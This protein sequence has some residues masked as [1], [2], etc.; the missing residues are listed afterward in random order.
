M[1]KC[2]IIPGPPAQIPLFGSITEAFV[3][4]ESKCFT[5]ITL[6]ACQKG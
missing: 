1:K 4:P 2:D 5:I 6:N 3:E